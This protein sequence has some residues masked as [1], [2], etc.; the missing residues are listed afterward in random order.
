M[1]LYEVLVLLFA[2][3]SAIGDILIVVSL[4]QMK[5]QKKDAHAEARRSKTIE[6]L[7]TFNQT[8][9]RYATAAGRVV[10]EFTLDQ[11][12]CLNNMETLILEKQK[13]EQIC[14]ICE[15]AAECSGN[16]GEKSKQPYCNPIATTKRATDGT[17]V[18]EHYEINPRVVVW[19]RG[20]TVSFLNTLEIIMLAKD[21]GIVEAERIDEEFRFLVEKADYV[22][23]NYLSH[24]GGIHWP[25]LMDFL[26]S[27]TATKVKRSKPL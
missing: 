24:G 1:E 16:G 26:E 4:L 2:G 10:E 6:V 9:S 22:L 23:K 17:V 21:I 18:N 3:I 13:M 14:K 15:F 19:L 25:H 5:Q 12:K 8:L 27:K 11:C 7:S 20:N